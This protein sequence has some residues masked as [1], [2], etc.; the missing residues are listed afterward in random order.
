VS[1]ARAE[2]V[3]RESG[4]DELLE[5]LLHLDALAGKPRI[6][7]AIAKPIAGDLGVDVDVVIAGGGLSLLYAPLL[8]ARGLRVLVA[9]RARIG[10]AHREWN[11][12]LTE[13][14]TLVRHGLLTEDDAA[15]L[16]VRTYAYGVC[17]WYE[18]GSYPVKG[19]L[20]CAFDG[21]A[22]L[23][24]VRTK[25]ENAGI[26]LL[27]GH[28]VVGLGEG[29]GAITVALEDASGTRRTVRARLVVDARGASS[30][31]ASAD[32]VCPTV[33]GVLRGLEEGTGPR[34]QDPNV[35]EI[36]ATTETLLAGQQHLWEAFPG[37]AG[38]TTVYLFYYTWAKRFRPGDLL[39][40]YARFFERLPLYRAGTPELVAPTFGLITGWSRLTPPPRAPGR[41]VMLVGDAAARH[42][43]LTYCGFG[44]LVRSLDGT[45]DRIAAAARSDHGLAGVSAE[46]TDRAIHGG[47][48]L[49]AAMMAEPP[50]DP[51]EHGAVNRLL[52]TAFRTLHG[53]PNDAYARLLRD[54]MSGR[55]FVTFLR[56]TAKQRPE[57]YRSVFERLGP[58]AVAKWGVNLAGGFLAR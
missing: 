14:A 6:D 32:L 33:G 5:R 20:D 29:P 58:A 10:R 44:D 3:V 38:E 1:R 56:A 12:Q 51:R 27:D 9:D 43:P 2:A 53:M 24:H 37:R 31:Y 52:D 16:V 48:G 26:Q 28:R 46:R 45:L 41:R 18:G 7:E 49:L 47:T 40:L 35:G 4:G 15:R 23:A 57:V 22:L 19:V 17:T 34:Q 21:R 39:E 13:L 36:L 55:E 50:S 11:A 54:E 8:A 30:P 25:A 42:S